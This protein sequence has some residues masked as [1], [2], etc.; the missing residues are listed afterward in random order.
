M[1]NH[2]GELPLSVQPAT[3]ILL[4]VKSALLDSIISIGVGGVSVMPRAGECHSC[5]IKV[6]RERGVGKKLPHRTWLSVNGN[7]ASE[8]TRIQ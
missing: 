1:I 2:R 5:F 8:K 7:R 3:V 4:L 6:F